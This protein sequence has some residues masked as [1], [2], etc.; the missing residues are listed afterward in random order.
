[1]RHDKVENK[2]IEITVPPEIRAGIKPLQVIHELD[3]KTPN[4]PHKGFT[5]NTG[6]FILRPTIALGT[7]NAAVVATVDS[8]NMKDGKI[9]ISFVPKVGKSQRVILLLNQFNPPG[10][11]AARSYNFQAPLDNGITN[12]NI[13]ET[14]SITFDFK[15]VAEG[16]YLVRVSVNGAENELEV[17][18]QGIFNEPKKDI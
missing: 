11:K 14:G 15:G 16:S 18:G 13:K 7:V 4:E 3:F 9:T 1:M 2:D 10:N 6:V 5:S 12:Q 17:N 8:V